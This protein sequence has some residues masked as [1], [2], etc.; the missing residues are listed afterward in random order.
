MSMHPSINYFKE[1]KGKCTMFIET[2]TYKGEGMILAREAGF[3]NIHSVDIIEHPEIIFQYDGVGTAKRYIQDSAHWLEWMLPAV[4][5][6]WMIWLDAHS[7][8]MEG[9]NENYPLMRELSAIKNSNKKPDV[10]LI[11]DLLYMTHPNITG[12]NVS[13]I[14][15]LIRTIDC[16]YEFE[17]LSN[18]IKNNILLACL[19]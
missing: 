13:E 17:Y 2:G 7:Q 11:D 9:E 4:N 12:F 19:K 14:V 5:E 8:I 18:P 16:D 10:I 3:T 15:E 6:P 1:Y